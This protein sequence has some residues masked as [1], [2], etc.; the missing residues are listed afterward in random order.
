MNAEKFDDKE[1]EDSIITYTFI[2]I[3]PSAYSENIAIK[4]TLNYVQNEIDPIIWLQIDSHPVNEFQIPSYITCIF[5][6]LYPTRSADL[7]AEHIKKVKS[8]KYFKYLF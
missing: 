2:L 5:S 4:K 3:L 6:A 8:A 7:H 1:N